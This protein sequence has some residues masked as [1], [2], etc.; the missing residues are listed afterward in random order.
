MSEEIEVFSRRLAA[1][2][3]ALVDEGV[4][5]AVLTDNANIMYLTGYW[6]ILSV[7]MPQAMVVTQD[8]T[9][10][11]VP[12]LEGAAVEALGLPWVEMRGFR[13]YPLQTGPT[14]DLART[15]TEALQ[16]CLED[17]GTAP[18]GIEFEG[19]RHVVLRD[20]PAIGSRGVVDI[21]GALRKLRSEKDSA[22]LAHIRRAAEIVAK[23]AASGR[24]IIARGAREQ[25]VAGAIAQTV[26]SHGA[27]ATHIVVGSGPRSVILH[28]EPTDRTLHEGDLVVVD[29]GVLVN[30]FWAE[31]A[32]TTVVGQPSKDQ[33]R[34][35]QA[36]VGAQ[37]AAAAG[38]APGMLARDVDAAARHVVT[39]QGYDGAHFNHSTG[40]GLGLLGMDLPAIAPDSGDRVPRSCA[41]TLEPGVYF[42]G[43]GGVRIED[44]YL[45]ADGRVEELTGWVSK[46]L[47]GTSQLS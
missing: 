18:V 10:L 44:T 40:H 7:M 11:L 14:V 32:R 19:V 8:H 12:A 16:S 42:A 28:A 47:A 9:I 33:V 4:R 36:V 23:A 31:I 46:E 22:A 17:I 13:N 27:R 2:R 1:L 24:A 15:F 5:T 26:W 41:L 34:W 30:G 37:A 35:H 29:I 6:T 38:L 20:V 21:G 39:S 25:D 43:R 3:N 45:L